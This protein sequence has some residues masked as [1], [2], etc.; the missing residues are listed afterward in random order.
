VTHAVRALASPV[1]WK[2]RYRKEVKEKS[3]EQ[4]DPHHEAV[5]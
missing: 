5:Q 3:L 4:Q 1:L 2:R